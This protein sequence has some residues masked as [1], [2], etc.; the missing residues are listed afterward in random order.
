MIQPDQPGDPTRKAERH[1]RPD[2]CLHCVLMTALE[3]WCERHAPRQDG[4]VVVDILHAVGKL[5]ECAVEITEFAGDRSQRRRAFRYA[6]DALDAALKSQ[7][8][9]K[10]VEVEVPAEH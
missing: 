4:K 3:G 5:A 8:T 9:K 2:S 7:R 1:D 10:L 6:H